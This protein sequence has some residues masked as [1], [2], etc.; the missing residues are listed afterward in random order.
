MEENLYT[1]YK[2]FLVEEVLQQTEEELSGDKQDVLHQIK[3]NKIT[4][5]VISL[6]YT[7]GSLIAGARET[8]ETITR[9]IEEREI[10]AELIRIGSM[11]MNSAEPV[12]DVQL[13]GKAKITFSHVLP[14]K[15][16]DILDAIFN[17]FVPEEYALGQHQNSL[18]EPW[19]K[20]PFM[21]EVPFLKDQQRTI[22]QNCGRI[23]PNSIE[24]YIAFGGYQSFIKAI[25]NYTPEEICDLVETSGLRGRG[26]EGYPTGKKWKN[27]LNSPAEQR[28]LIC[29][30]GESDP[31]AS[32]ERII[33]ES[34]PHS[35]VESVAI[36]AYALG[37]QK[38]YIYLESEYEMAI[39]RLQVAINTAKSYGILGHDIFSSGF[40]LNIHLFKGAGA[41]VC[42]E[43]TALIASLEGKRGMPRP[44]PPYPSKVGLFGQPTTVNNVETLLNIPVII[45]YGPDW[46]KKT[47][48]EESSGTKIFSLSGKIERTGLVEIPMGTPLRDIIY[49]IGGG[50]PDNS[51]LKG[52]LVGG[53]A[54]GVLTYEHLDNKIDYDSVKSLGGALGSG[55]LVVIDNHTCVI[56]TVKYYMDFLKQESCGKCIPCREG[57]RRMH[58]ILE[59]ISR[60]PSDENGHNTLQRFKG[61]M[62]LEKLAYVIRDTSL[63]GLGQRASNP[64]LSTLKWFREEY[65]EHIFDR[66]CKA[67]VCQELRTFYIDVD[68]CTGCTI[69]AKKCP[70]G[71]IF[72]TQK[73]PH[74]IVQEK[75]IGCGICYDSCKFGAV[76]SK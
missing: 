75:C 22:L 8:Y 73:H 66:Q 39:E 16:S 13:P 19:E 17:N 32:M 47:G 72:G 33:M 38:A 5:P 45:N 43:E 24:E 9:Y 42:G 27:T 31:G 3:R 37:A 62:H 51:E 15:V 12:M 70:T 10:D 52:V 7:S 60:K 18:H 59:N 65:E 20:L 57:I 76:I 44:K 36:S 61:V 40:N 23:N 2:D 49:K 55:G 63:C 26:G 54:G 4:R 1:N 50:M 71:A 28:Y 69:C 68:K 67:G 14:E 34:D 21:D 64:V 56:D 6:S 74:F 29:N 30:A 41:Y 58:E 48:T 46:Y 35:I 11:G 53:P 25:N